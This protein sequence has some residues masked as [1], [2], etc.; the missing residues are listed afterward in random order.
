MEFTREITADLT[1]SLDG[2]AFRPD[3][4]GCEGEFVY[5]TW[6]GGQTG[7]PRVACALAQVPAGT[8]ADEARQFLL[9]LRRTLARR[10]VRLPWP[11]R[12]ATISVLLADHETWRDLQA[13]RDRLLD[14]R[15]LHVNVLLATVLVDRDHAESC[16]DITWG[17][18]DA[19]EPYHAIRAGVDQCCRRHQRRRRDRPAVA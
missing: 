11:R 16:A 12:L 2:L 6:L 3:A 4:N 7:S 17:L 1:R 19:D 18:V 9:S 13:R 8:G 5:R 15:G 10:H 14:A